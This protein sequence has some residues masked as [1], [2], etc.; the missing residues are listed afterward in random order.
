MLNVILVTDLGETQTSAIAAVSA[1]TEIKVIAAVPINELTA[2]WQNKYKADLVVMSN[3]AVDHLIGSKFGKVMRDREHVI[4]KTRHGIQL[5]AVAD[6]YYFKA[7]HKYVIA[8]HN[9]GHLLIEDSLDSLENEF[10]SDFIR[11]HRKILVS[12][13]KIERLIKD[14]SGKY[15]IKLRDISELLMV[16]RRKLSIVRKILS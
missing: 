4:S 16:S 10:G 15:F 9:N 7:E 5:L 14:P 8:S 3:A 6:I 1:S 11:I 12:K 13:Q 2:E